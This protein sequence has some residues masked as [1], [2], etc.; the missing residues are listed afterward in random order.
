M[1]TLPSTSKILSITGTLHLKTQGRPLH[2]FLQVYARKWAD[3]HAIYNMT[4]CASSVF[5]YGQ[6]VLKVTM[7]VSQLA[8]KHVIEYILGSI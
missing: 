6:G 4:A 5:V 2:N 7:D 3:R 8:K 1:L